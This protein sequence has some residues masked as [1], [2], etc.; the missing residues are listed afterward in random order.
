MTI[1]LL[2]HSKRLRDACEWLISS[3]RL[4]KGQASFKYNTQGALVI[5]AMGTRYSDAGSAFHVQELS[6]VMIAPRVSPK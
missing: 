5:E 2:H 3:K 1:E 4:S 6:A